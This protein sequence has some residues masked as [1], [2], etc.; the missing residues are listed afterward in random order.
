METKSRV[1][2]LCELEAGRSGDCFV[3]LAA[4]DMAKTRDGKPYY[5]VSFRDAVRT[6]T[7]MVWSDSNW[8]SECDEK[9]QVGA[10]YKVRCR[11]SETSY[12]PQLD[13]DRI[14]DVVEDDCTEGFDP[15]DF[16]QS[17]RFD[18]DVMFQELLELA[19]TE[20]SDLALR[21]LAVELL[22]DHADAIKHIPA[23][24]RNHH[25][26]A[27]GYLEHVLSMT[28]TAVFLADKYREHYP[29]MK[30][31]LSKSLVVAGAVLH[32][33]GKLLEL[34]VQPQGA[35]YSARGRL[36]GH[37]LLGRDLVREKAATIEQLDAETLLRLEHIIVSH[38]NLPEWGSP[39]APHTPE[40]LLVHFADDIDAKFFMMAAHLADES[41]RADEFT[42]RN[43]PLGRRI[44]RGLK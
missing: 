36:I 21:Q 35:E 44:F 29:Q 6:A 16:F 32:D 8:F 19:E 31:P 22:T 9:W 5:R 15:F 4:K 26:F 23:A 34:D 20:I 13:I 24:T 33:I 1:I 18:V 43:N 10:F 12:G 42:S 41:E 7:A 3:L 37:I 28:R 39:I 14:R 40:A 38:Q 30:P 17:T 27:G 2:R 25:A 11:Y